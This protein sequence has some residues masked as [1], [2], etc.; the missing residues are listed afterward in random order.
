MSTRCAGAKKGLALLCAVVVWISGCFLRRTS[1]KPTIAFYAPGPVLPA[2]SRADLEPPPDI[3]IESFS[4]TP[5]LETLRNAPPRP[6]ISAARSDNEPVKS[7]PEPEPQIAPEFS[8]A[9]MDAAQTETRSNLDSV[10]KNLALAMGKTLNTSQQDLIDKAR[11]F[12]ASAQAAVRSGD[13]VRARTLSKKAQLLSQ[14][15]AD[16]L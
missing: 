6:R 7:E 4:A 10:Q 9:E 3:S 15:L 16:S 8:S 1:A 14:E 12:A 13:W 2:K 11:G 5:G